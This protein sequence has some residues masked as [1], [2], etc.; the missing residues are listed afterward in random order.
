MNPE[1]FAKETP[2]PFDV[3]QD[4]ETELRC[5]LDKKKPANSLHSKLLSTRL[6][7]LST[8]IVVDLGQRGLH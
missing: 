5:R 3:L 1:V 4:C 6:E 7:F 2:N 8:K